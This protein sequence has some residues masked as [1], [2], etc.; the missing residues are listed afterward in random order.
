MNTQKFNDI[1][2]GELLNNFY[3]DR[4]SDWLGILLP[5]YTLLLLGVCMKYLKNEED[6]KDAVQQIFFK[7]INELSKYKVNYFKSWIYMIAKNYCLMK[8]R[9]KSKIPMEI[10]ESVATADE[11]KEMDVLIEKDEL[12]NKMNEVLKQLNN[13]Q[14]QCLTLFY[15][16][17]KSYSEI[18]SIT[19]YQVM[20]VKSHIQNGKRNL[21]LLMKKTIQHKNSTT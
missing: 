18:A 10:N 2:D 20:S 14:R 9:D 15:L 13:E 21:R 1:T 16:E 19:G 5:R 3:S 6:A 12:L 11:P 4:N 17:K 7:A 8:L